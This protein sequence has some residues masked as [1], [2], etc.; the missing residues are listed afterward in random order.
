[1]ASQSMDIENDS[2]EVVWIPTAE[3]TVEFTAPPPPSQGFHSISPTMPTFLASEKTEWCVNLGKA[4][5]VP[6]APSTSARHY[7]LF[8]LSRSRIESQK[9][10]STLRPPNVKL[11]DYWQVTFTFAET[12]FTVDSFL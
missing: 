12:T 4:E 3:E 8:V 5:P 11:L 10:S 7:V 1:M 2:F 9:L 6:F